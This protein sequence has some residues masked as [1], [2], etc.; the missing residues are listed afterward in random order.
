MWMPQREFFLAT[1]FLVFD[2]ELLIGERR[3][4]LCNVEVRFAKSNK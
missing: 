2:F 4:L 1:G 3:D